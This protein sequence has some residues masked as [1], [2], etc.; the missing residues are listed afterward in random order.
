MFK[1]DFELPR[2]VVAASVATNSH[3]NIKS[4][5]IYLVAE[6]IVAKAQK[7]NTL[8]I[9]CD[10]C[11]KILNFKKVLTLSNLLQSILSKKI[12]HVFFS[13]IFIFFSLKMD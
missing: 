2:I 5:F 9:F 13:I 11:F 12:L 3:V 7:Y 6:G 4:V 1:V 10:K 8:S